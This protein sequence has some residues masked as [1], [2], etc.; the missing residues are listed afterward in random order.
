MT[1][2]FDQEQLHFAAED[3]NLNKVKNLIDAGYD[4]NV[5]D[6]SMELT[7]LHYAV[8]AEKFKVAE[9]LLSIGANINAHVE[10][11]A[12]ETPLG[13]VAQTCSY[14]MAEFLIKNGANP[15]IPGWMQL[16]AIDRSKKRKKEEGQRVYELL[17]KTAKKNFNYAA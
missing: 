15:V 12:G 7:P 4:V 8:R 17:L 5:L 1:D 9:Y 6:E 3:G 14:E 2:W 13:N 10:E 16:T 11:K